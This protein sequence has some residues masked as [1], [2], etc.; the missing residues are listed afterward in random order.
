M[1]KSRSLVLIIVVLLMVALPD[2]TLAQENPP[3]FF[4]GTVTIDGVLAPNGTVITALIDGI[5]Q[6][7]TS[8]G[9]G[10]AYTLLVSQGAGTGIT[11]KIGNLDANETATWEQ[12]GATALNLTAVAPPGANLTLSHQEIVANQD[13]TISGS[14]FAEGGDVCVLEGDITFN[15][16][17]LKLDDPDNC[18]TFI[19]VTDGILL[20]S[21]GTFTLTVRV[22]S[23]SGDIPTALLVEG[24]H[25]LKVID[26]NGVVGTINL[27]IPERQLAANPAGAEPGDLLTITGQRFIASNPDG[28]STTIDIEYVCLPNIT[29]ATAIT[30]GSG[31]FQV[32]ISIPNACITP[33][34]NVISA[35]IRVSG[36]STGVVE[37]INHGLGAGCVPPP[38][39]DW[40]VTQDCT[41][42][43][44]ATAPGNV[45]VEENI[46]LTIAEDAALDIDFL[47]FHL[48]IK[49]GAKVVIRDGGK[50]H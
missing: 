47:N 23:T 27:T 10:G 30:D 43:G 39:G 41:L 36:N 20:T 22:H 14:G 7:S 12:G 13:L 21:G 40:T 44:S 34:T 31:N 29:S 28:L 19:S 24:T 18:P 15:N 8:V 4:T 48:L 3:H 2:A 46:A 6:G 37:V 5:E 45:I 17:P 25:E 9:S 16:V 49:S 38:S 33:S 35:E 32:A 26:T 42:S 50:I 11:F 1:Q